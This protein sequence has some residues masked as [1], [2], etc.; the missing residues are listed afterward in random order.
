MENKLGLIHY[1]LGYLELI[2]YSIEVSFEPDVL[3]HPVFYAI[4]GLIDFMFLL[5][6]FIV[7]RTSYV[8]SS[9][10]EEILYSGK[11]VWNYL[12]GRFWI[13]LLATIPFD[14]IGIV[15]FGGSTTALQLFGILKLVRIARLSKI[16]AYLNVK[17]DFKLILKLAKLVFFLMMYLH[18]LG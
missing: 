11:I 10:G 17:E 2:Y 16:I 7:F 5:D 12:F 9:T 18:L 3:N 14:V 1:D 15:I 13:D 6:I 4:N 8:D